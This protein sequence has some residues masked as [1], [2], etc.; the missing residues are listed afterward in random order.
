MKKVFL[1]ILIIFTFNH[2]HSQENDSLIV[3]EIENYNCVR[4]QAEPIVLKSVYPKTEFH[5]NKDS[6]S[7]IETILINETEKVTINN[8]GCEYYTLNFIFETKNYTG[9]LSN[10]YYWYKASYDLVNNIK[11][12]LDSPID[13]EAGLKVYLKYVEKNKN[14]LELNTQIDFGQT[15]LY[16]I[17]DFVTLHEITK[18]EDNYFVNISFSTG[19]L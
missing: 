16:A 6:L 1:T 5:L 14:H 2:F 4:G 18:I 12:G 17:R 7:G 19:P 15:E 8:V 11:A 13:I 3:E 10:F 9:D